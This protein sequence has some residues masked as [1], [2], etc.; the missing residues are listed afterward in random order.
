[1]KVVAFIEDRAV[2]RRILCH[3]RLWKEPDPHP[4]PVIEPPMSIDI[5]YVPCYE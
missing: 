3:L 1:M 4:P 5:E 2:I